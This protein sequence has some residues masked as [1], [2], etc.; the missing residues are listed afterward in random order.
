VPD[1]KQLDAVSRKPER[2]ES[3]FGNWRREVNEVDQGWEIRFDYVAS[4]ERFA[5]HD[6]REFSEFQRKAIDAI[7]QPLVL[8]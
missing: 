6:Y 5:P 7:E 1:G 8:Q 2:G 3:K 4:E